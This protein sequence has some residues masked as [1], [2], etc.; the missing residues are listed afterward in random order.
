MLR[1]YVYK[2]YQV[3]GLLMGVCVGCMT[4]SDLYLL[5]GLLAKG[6][7]EF[8]PGIDV[9][10]KGVTMGPSAL[11]SCRANQEGTVLG[12]NWLTKTFT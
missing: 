8:A 11:V 12:S 10:V 6:N 4:R 5:F 1:N 2:L 9:Q 7:S 3:L